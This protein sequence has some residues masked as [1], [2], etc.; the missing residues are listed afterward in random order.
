ME[1]KVL[2]AD[3]DSGM[4]LVLRKMVERVEGFEVMGEA[5]DGEEVLRL[6]NEH[7]PH[8]IFMDVDMPLLSGVEAAKKIMDIDPRTI[9]IFAT[10]HEE[11]MPEAFAVYA[12]DYIVKPF[13][14]ERVEQTL[15]R[16]REQ[17][18]YAKYSSVSSITARQEKGLGKLMLRNKEG[19]S[20][21]D[22]QDII[23][24]QREDRST[25][26]YTQKERYATSEGL[27]EIEERLDKTLF[28]RSH[29]SYIIN[30]SMIHKIH[31]YGRWTFLV[32]FKNTEQDALLTS[33]RYEILEKLFS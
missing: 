20:L 33:E 26:V 23:L 8:V 10:G 32:K 9:L 4:R 21:I 27:S 31:P 12:F 3:D 7:H 30:L 28:F 1:R 11:Y 13:K 6:V 2:L 25:V 22:M 17:E 15:K 16:I 19:I 5:K 18:E 24:I 14:S 29:K